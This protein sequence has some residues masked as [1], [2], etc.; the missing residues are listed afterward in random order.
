MNRTRCETSIVIITS[1]HPQRSCE[2]YVFTVVCLSTRGLPQCMLGHHTTPPRSTP[3]GKHIYPGK[4][5][6]ERQLPL[7]MVRILLEC[8]LVDI[9][10][11]SNNTPILLISSFLHTFIFNFFTLTPNIFRTTM[12]DK[13]HNPALHDHVSCQITCSKSNFLDV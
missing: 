3:P 8:I 5:T 11:I 13:Y 12:L 6:P 4:H 1:Y 10:L 2:G 7:Q 9:K